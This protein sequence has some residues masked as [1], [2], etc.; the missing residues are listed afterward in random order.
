MV[1]IFFLKKKNY[2]II[3]VKVKI[4]LIS[5][6]CTT[7]LEYQVYHSYGLQPADHSLVYT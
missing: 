5:F 7:V 6:I 1:A 2:S 3:H 4:M